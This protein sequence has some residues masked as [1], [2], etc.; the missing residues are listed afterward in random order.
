MGAGASARRRSSELT[1]EAEA[2]FEL[3]QVK[4]LKAR[5]FAAAVTSE[6][7]VSAVLRPLD[8]LG[9]RMLEDRK[10]PGS[11]RANVDF[12]LVG[13]GGVIV[14]DAKHWSELEVRNGS[15]FRGEACED[16]EV[17]KLLGLTDT[18]AQGLVPTGLVDAAIRPVMTFTS[19]PVEA[20][21]LGP[22][23]VIGAAGL[24]TWLSRL[25]ERLTSTQIAQVTDT[26]ADLCPEATTGE[27][28]PPG[29]LRRRRRPTPRMEQSLAQESLVD[30]EAITEALIESALAAPIEDWM[31]FLHPEQ[32]KL[33]RSQWNGPAR[34]RGPAG[35][36][37]TVVGLHRAVHLAERSAE[38]VLF[39]SFVKTLP[40]VMSSLAQR[41][42]PTAAEQIE[43]I[44][45]HALAHKVLR[46]VERPVSIN[47]V[48][49]SRAFQQAWRRTHA[50]GRLAAIE[51]R[52]AYWREEID[53][54]IKGRGLTSFDSYKELRRVGR[55][56]RMRA[57][58]RE[59]MWDLYIAYE[60]YLQESGCQDFNDLLLQAEDAVTDYPALFSY[61]SVI[62]D[63]AQDLN[64]VGLRFLTSIAGDGTNRL[65]IIGDGQQS[66]YPGG[67]TLAEAGVSVS[68]RGTVLKTNYRNT[69][70]ILDEAARIV[71]QDTFLDLDEALESGVR[72]TETVRHG[73]R[74]IRATAR[75][76]QDLNAALTSQIRRTRDALGVPWGDMAVLVERRRDVDDYSRALRRAGIPTIELTK[77]D[78]VTVDHVKVGTFKRAKG[79]EF[80]YVLMP[81][82]TN[83]APEMWPGETDET[84]AERCERL[85]R[86]LYVG[87]TRARDGLWLGYLEP[88]AM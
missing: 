75:T 9:W 79:L 54:V 7:E 30:V 21:A 15:I 28:G 50:A 36:G 34:V 74:P 53:H 63:E 32:N 4:R 77:Y 19:H 59:L 57:E 39:T 25:P 72:E 87:M 20:T 16:D 56:T 17:D 46:T 11:Q 51:E 26:V 5:N 82:L 24:V 14:L 49:A 58:D 78:G 81:G 86:E 6:R 65:L 80:K 1:H 40:V 83:E 2:L 45:V 84:Y 70:E 8:T 37:K 41:L 33:V 23:T 44:G 48:A 22:V 85:R 38:P 68:G 35:T 18:I 69:V 27:S 3:A 10:W 42:S 31:T 88:G 43:F 13:P 66:V 73:H 71:A 55:K 62:L 47:P 60:D 52:P 61:G 29:F 67:F 12:V 76:Q 64:L